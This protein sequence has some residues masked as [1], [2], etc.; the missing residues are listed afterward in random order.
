M[1]L[2]LLSHRLLAAIC[3]TMAA[4]AAYASPADVITEQL[5]QARPDLQL[6]N[7]KSSPVEGIQEV[8]L[9]DGSVIYV[10][11]NGKHFFYGELFQINSSGFTNLTEARNN[12]SRKEALAGVSRDQ[13]V[14]YSP[15]GETKASVTVFTDI[16]CGYCRKLHMEMAKMNELGIEVRYMAFPRAGVKRG[17]DYTPSYTKIASAWCA[18]DPLAALTD[19][20]MGK[21]IPKN[22]CKNNP[23]EAQYLLGQKM[24]IRGT[25]AMILEDGSMVPGYL[26]ADQLAGRLG[27]Q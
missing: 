23:I 10:S 20:K 6:K 17:S 9:A 21:D 8:E 24:G 26:P 22:I 3:F 11:D 2:R 4:T 27:I 12:V 7:V 15:K 13:Q 18:K 14:V 1:L 5:K 19:A 25:P 16:D